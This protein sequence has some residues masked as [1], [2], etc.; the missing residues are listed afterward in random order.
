MVYYIVEASHLF[1]AG[2]K[3]QTQFFVLDVVNFLH[4]EF[5]ASAGEA[6]TVVLHGSMKDE[7][8]KR[9]AAALERHGVEVIRMKPIDS[10]IG[11]KVFYKPAFYMHQMM[12]STI[13]ERSLVVLIGFHNP[14]YLSFLEKYAPLYAISLAAFSTP[15]KK[16]GMMTIPK[17]FTPHLVKTIDLD[18]FV[19]Q[20]KAEF[21][22]KPSSKP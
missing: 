5:F 22:Q 4:R 12:G 15:S 13:H 10:V 16:Q 21:K 18:E 2:D 17:D 19:A 6:K 11:G 1:R 9:Y 3:F 20:I 14:R 8:A 7:Q